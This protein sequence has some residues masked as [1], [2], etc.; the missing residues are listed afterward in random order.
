MTQTIATNQGLLQS[1]PQA[2]L[3]AQAKNSIPEYEIDATT[4]VFGNLY[5]VWVGMNL[6]GTFYQRFS[7]QLWVSQ[8]IRSNERRV[9]QTDE[10]AIAAVL[11]A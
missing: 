3:I 6:R 10:E 8:P 4:D 2:H 5:R 11:N 7:D 9:W 1:E